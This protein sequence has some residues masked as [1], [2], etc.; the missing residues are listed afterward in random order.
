MRF[1]QR[2][3]VT[4]SVIFDRL[5]KDGVPV[6]GKGSFKKKTRLERVRAVGGRESYSR[7][8]DSL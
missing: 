6:T 7:Q 5:S 4:A 2:W 1:T 8:R 3:V